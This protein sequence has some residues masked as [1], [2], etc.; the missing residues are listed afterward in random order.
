ML[1]IEVV[2]GRLPEA[3]TGDVATDAPTEGMISEELWERHFAADP[4][5]IGREIEVAGNNVVIVGIARR[6]TRF[7]VHPEG[8][9][10][11]IDVWLPRPA[12][13]QRG[14]TFGRRALVRVAD[15]FTFASASAEINEIAERNRGRDFGNED[16]RGTYA[17][18][19]LHD[20]LV[21]GVR[22]ILYLLLGAVG[23]VLLL[24]CVNVANLLLV[25]S[26][27]RR[28]EWAIR[29]ALGATRARI[30]RLGLTEGLVLAVFGG[31]LGTAV[32]AGCLRL[33][34]LIMPGTLPRGTEIGI[35]SAVLLFAA[36]T[37][38]VTA[39]LF[40]LVPAW[41]ASRVDLQD[42]LKEGARTVTE[43]GGR[44]S[45]ALITAQFA[46]AMVLVIGAGL[47][48]RTVV[49]LN[50]VD[51]GFEVDG[52]LTFEVLLPAQMWE[53]PALRLQFYREASDRLEAL[54]GVES[55]SWTNIV[56][57]SG[58]FN[59]ASWAYD[60]ETVERFGELTAYFRRA[61]PGYFR[62]LG[63]PILAGRDFNA[64]DVDN[65]RY[66]LIVSQRM[67]D[68]AWPGESP[69]G[70]FVKID[71]ATPSGMTELRDT[72][73]VGVV[74]SSREVTL[75]GDE[76]PTAYLPA[77]STRAVNRAMVR[78]AG[79]PTE[80][81]PVV[82]ELVRELGIRRPLD[83]V[84]AVRRNI[85]DATEDSRFVL[86]LTGGFSAL[87]VLLAALGIYGVVSH[88]VGQRQH[89]I[90][91]RMALGAQRASVRAMV[92]RQGLA[93]VAGGVGLGTL[94]AW[95]VTRL[96]GSLLYDVSPTDPV[97]FAAV[98]GLLFA[99][100]AL[101]CLLPAARATRVEP[102]TALRDA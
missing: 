9:R 46:F 45:R 5:M 66:V 101:A 90:G 67:A 88:L 36:A 32:A 39:I 92:M 63:M 95:G 31:A 33:L 12:I 43:G 100:A 26:L 15:G 41:N 96:I 102:V 71:F 64:D 24:V 68:L 19:A 48:L 23:F 53:E 69:L 37:S 59:T 76:P 27:Q 13:T 42:S 81:I 97:T 93:V 4:E 94:L 89:E 14:N 62:T 51:V 20:R 86:T 34:P 56:P 29:G 47:M 44:L 8:E 55:A 85:D 7:L 16:G 78:T 87:A 73:V 74:P 77:W 2:R 17:V 57:L 82:R 75:S 99:V 80:L 35:N 6:G 61:T 10:E 79:E 30:L 25:R 38:V 3:M 1:A 22:P 50:N 91:V 49:N 21:Q 58:G 60:D 11:R 40:G 65:D 83:N 28:Q 70:K 52:L 18:V 72:E 84:R 98:V 54:P